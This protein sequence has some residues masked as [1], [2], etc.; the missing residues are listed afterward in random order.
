M[1][2]SNCGK[3]IDNNAEFCPNCGSKLEV[4]NAEE[5]NTEPNMSSNEKEDKYVRPEKVKFSE[6]WLLAKIVFFQYFDISFISITLEDGINEILYLSVWSGLVAGILLTMLFGYFSMRNISL[7]GGNPYMLKPNI[8]DKILLKL[9]KGSKY[10]IDLVGGVFVITTVIR[11]IQNSR[12]WGYFSLI[13]WLE[14]VQ[15]CDGWLILIGFIYSIKLLLMALK[16]KR[17][18]EKNELGR[19]KNVL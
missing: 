9:V 14:A 12:L 1:F 16:S 8:Q 4:K 15:Y 18:W 17:W 11:I 6:R 10:A 7:Y 13:T 2:C 5:K 19:R 3:E